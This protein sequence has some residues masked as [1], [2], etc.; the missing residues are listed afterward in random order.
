MNQH[1]HT[2]AFCPTVYPCGMDH[3]FASPTLRGGGGGR[4][5]PE[6]RTANLVAL[7]RLEKARRATLYA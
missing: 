3:Q 5:C 4:C 2:C 7:D 1:V 6:C